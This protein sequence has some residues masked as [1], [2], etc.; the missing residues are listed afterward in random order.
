MN[1]NKFEALPSTEKGN[2]NYITNFDKQYNLDL[3]IFGN[4]ID[5]NPILNAFLLLNI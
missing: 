1:K 2:L 5:I 3:N 4:I